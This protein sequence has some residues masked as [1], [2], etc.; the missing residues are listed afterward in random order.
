MVHLSYRPRSILVT[1]ILIQT[2]CCF[3]SSIPSWHEFTHYE[4]SHADYFPRGGTL[5][6]HL[7]LMI[8]QNNITL[9]TTLADMKTRSNRLK[10]AK[11][12]VDKFKIRST[13]ETAAC[14]DTCILEN[15]AQR[16][17][18][19]VEQHTNILGIGA[20]SIKK[21]WLHGKHLLYHRGSL[22]V[23]PAIEKFGEWEERAIQF[24]ANF[25]SDTSTPSLAN[26]NPPPVIFDVGANM[27][28]FTLALHDHFPNY[29]YHAFEPQRKLF[30]IIGANVALLGVEQ[31][32]IT[33]N[34]GVSD[35]TEI[36][37][38]PV[39]T[40]AGNLAY[41]QR[42]RFAQISVAPGYHDY[43][44]NFS[45][46]QVQGITL[47]SLMFPD[48]IH[49]TI[50]IRCPVLVKIDVE[51]FERKVLLGMK[52][53]F[54]HDC[55]PAL[56]FEHHQGQAAKDVVEMLLSFGYHDCY[57]HIFDY[58]R[59]RHNWMNDLFEGNQW[60]NSTMSS[61]IFCIPSQFEAS[62]G[63]SISTSL[64][65]AIADGLIVRID[66]ETWGGRKKICGMNIELC[67]GGGSSSSSSSL[68][69]V[70]S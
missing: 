7:K 67:G 48:N 22:N 10:F 30:N 60:A 38:V 58:I 29:E 2:C 6:I 24:L 47:S 12:V 65:Q 18:A 33:H 23:A 56:Y 59:P 28:L 42:A 32:I 49:N 9:H 61:N 40:R 35:R 44:S 64:D 8:D 45:T 1:A 50:A 34:V 69:G 26:G 13:T 66:K 21:K 52:Q 31:N 25:L 5:P 16:L 41:G 68:G 3:V 4:Q 46:Y 57:H 17:H 39:V 20:I 54:V 37:K 14:N 53:M 70:E 55:L 62:R 27:G 43:E 51:G 36:L 19:K 15:I 63:G 11:Q